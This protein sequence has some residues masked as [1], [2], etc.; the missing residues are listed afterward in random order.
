MLS[1]LFESR[2]SAGLDAFD[3]CGYS[4]DIYNNTVEHSEMN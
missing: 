1:A 3:C 4:N 2:F